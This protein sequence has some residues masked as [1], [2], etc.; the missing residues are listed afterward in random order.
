MGIVETFAQSYG[1][2]DDRPGDAHEG[3]GQEVG[4]AALPRD[5]RVRRPRGRRRRATPPS[6]ASTR[7][8]DSGAYLNNFAVMLEKPNSAFHLD[9][10]GGGVGRDDQY[11]GVDV[12][13]TTRGECAATFSETPHVFTSTYRSLWD[14]VGRAALHLPD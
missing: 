5:R 1:T 14:G 3:A 13:S 6:S 4:R 2:A 9:A 10:V 11:Y 7:I 8:C 12:G